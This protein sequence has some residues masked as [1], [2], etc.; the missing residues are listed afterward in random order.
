MQFQS[1]AATTRIQK[2]EAR[3]RAE[4][5][6]DPCPMSMG[7]VP[8]RVVTRAV[9]DVT[10]LWK[11]GG[12]EWY[13]SIAVYDDRLDWEWRADGR[14]DGG[15]TTDAVPESFWLKLRALMSR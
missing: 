5:L 2:L 1:P 7:I 15:T 14:S 3:W 9:G 11:G 10:L 6:P 4:G 8:G 12:G 13:A